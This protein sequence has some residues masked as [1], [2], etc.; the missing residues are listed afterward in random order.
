MEHN[1][2]IFI[3]RWRLGR[4]NVNAGHA[5]SDVLSTSDVYA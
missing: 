3:D 2:S 4:A 5:D 1:N